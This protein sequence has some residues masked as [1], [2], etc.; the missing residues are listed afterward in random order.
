MSKEPEVQT[1]LAVRTEKVTALA[2]KAAGTVQALKTQMQEMSKHAIVLSPVQQTSSIMPMHQVAFSVVTIDTS[3]P[4]KVGSQSIGPEVYQ[5]HFC[6]RDEVA[7]G[8]VALSK[9]MRAAGISIKSTDR[10]DGYKHPYFCHYSATLSFREWDGTPATMTESKELDLRDADPDSGR[11]I[12]AALDQM[13]DKQ[14]KLQTRRIAAARQ[15]IAQLCETMAV[16]RTLRLILSLQQKYNKQELEQ[17]PFVCLKLVPALEGHMDD[18]RVKD[19]VLGTALGVEG[20]LYGSKAL[21][22]APPGHETVHVGGG[23]TVPVD[24]STGEVLEPESDWVPD[25]L[26]PDPEPAPATPEHICTCPC[27]C[28]SEIT[29]AVAEATTRLVKAPRCQECFPQKGFNEDKHSKL[30]AP[31]ADLGMVGRDGK[32]IT[33]ER[34][35]Q[36]VAVARGQS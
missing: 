28:Q 6:D 14:G 15:H 9:L 7:L 19:A 26:P 20:A 22:A 24:T 29:A 25:D 23:Q 33:M 8:K 1:A 3:M 5:A 18:P 4:K 17:K 36:L 34:C 2:S 12:G 30:L 11:P 27:G 31:S 21:P 16:E 13:R 10:K 35:L 32:P